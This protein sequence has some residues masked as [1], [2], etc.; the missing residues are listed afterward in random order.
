M[1]EQI[2]QWNA[3]W[4]GPNSGITDD[5]QRFL[6]CIVDISVMCAARS[7]NT[8]ATVRSG[9]CTK[10]DRMMATDA[11]SYSTKLSPQR[12]PP[13]TEIGYLYFDKQPVAEQ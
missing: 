8:S 6:C 13:D 9:Q 1:R 2:K 7:C 3:S 4:D 11:A 5:D 10:C 12:C